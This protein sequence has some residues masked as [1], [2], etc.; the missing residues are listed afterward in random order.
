MREDM[1][2]VIMER[3]RIIDSIER[4]GRCRSLEDL[5]KQQGMRRSQRE[6]GGYKMLNENLA[7]LRRFLERQVG[8]PWGKVYSEIAQRLRVYSTV[9][10]HVRD[11]L[12]DFVATRPRRGASDCRRSTRNEDGQSLWYQPLYVDPKDGILKRTDKLPEI[13][14]RRQR[15][16]QRSR[17]LPPI[18]RI[19]LALERE[20]RRIAGIWY[21][22]A[23]APLPDPEYRVITGLQKVPLKRYHRN[24]PAVEMEMTVRRLVTR[25]VIDCT[26]GRSIPAGPEI[27]EEPAW[28]EYRRSHP[29]RRYAVSKRQL[30]RKQ[31]RRH[32]V[33]L[34]ATT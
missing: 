21:E 34:R 6:R 9:Q 18:D 20:L 7:P 28:K 13:K 30:S 19:A 23:L 10:Q 33:E 5:P 24:S 2:R 22:V 4:K 26:T 14:A 12:S 31:L 17:R 27:D 29:D 32:G 3:P 15:A 1:S 16:A 11:H 25:S 8:R